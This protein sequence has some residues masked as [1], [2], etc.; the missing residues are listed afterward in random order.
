MC[1]HRFEDFLEA[2]LPRI[3]WLVH[4]IRMPGMQRQFLNSRKI[5]AMSGRFLLCAAIV[6]VI[7]LPLPVHAADLPVAAAVAGIS[8]HSQSLPL[9]CEARTAVDWAAF[10]GASIGEQTF[11]DALPKTDNPETGF[12][13]NVYDAPGS[14]PPNGYGVYEAPL[15]QLLSANGVPALERR[16]ASESELQS[17]IAAGRPAIVW[18][19]YGF[20]VTT[21][22]DRTAADG[23]VY[24]VAPF[25]HTG[26]VIG[27]DPSS[28]TVI[29]AFSGMANRVDRAQFL[30]SWAVLGNRAVIADGS[31]PLAPPPDAAPVSTPTT[32][33]F[34]TVRPG[35]SLTVIA[36]QIGVDWAELAS[37]NKL[38]LPYTIY[39]G[40]Q[41]LIPW[42]GTPTPAGPET[43]PAPSDSP[44]PPSAY[45]V[46][47][48]DSISV[49]AKRFGI[50]WPAL[51]TAN[52]LRW[53]YTIYPGQ[54][55]NL[56]G[57]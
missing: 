57:R 3:P 6:T 35:E 40:Q 41:L 15:A 32:P 11:F 16:N 51:A 9:D 49:I 43:Q 29:D 37:V 52:A 22:Y 13:G 54:V 47:A 48:G 42:T 36:K 14:L 8:G 23:S 34:Y 20:R 27:Y 55:L 24:S 50:Y 21:L 30:N 10:F 17:E 46:Q 44:S 5:T 53:P 31:A 38:A 18:Y 19:I 56:P 2:V 33:T 45:T 12:V 1:P 28:Y 39:P 7:L 25:E 4:P 26:I